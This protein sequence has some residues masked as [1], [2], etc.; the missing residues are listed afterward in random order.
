MVLCVYFWRLYTVLV[1]IKLL[2]LLILLLATGAFFIFRPDNTVRAPGNEPAENNKQSNSPKPSETPAF[3]KTKHSLRDPASLWVIVNKRQP[4]NPASFRPDDLVYPKVS[5]RVPGNEIM[6]MRTEA[7]AATEKMFAD[8]KLAGLNLEI[9]SAYRS[10]SFQ[11][12]L[13]NNYVRTQGQAA[14]D[15]QSARPGYSEHQTGLAVD[16]QPVGG[17]CHLEEC[18]GDL[19]EG[20]WLLANAHKYGFVLRYPKDKQQITGYVYEPWHYRFV[21][22]ELS[23][24]INKNNNVTLEE[25]FGLGP[26]PDYN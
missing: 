3:N 8:A 2:I 16:I 11:T 7:A 19:P 23:A 10:Y 18:F 22:T 12:G 1:K 9:S 24:E 21:G 20:I 17:K 5:Q 26:A 4:L 6:R 14:A 13:Y 15:N 25:F